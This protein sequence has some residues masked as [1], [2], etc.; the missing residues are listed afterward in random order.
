VL[1][2]DPTNATSAAYNPLL[3]VRKGEWEVRDV[4]N[5]TLG[6]GFGDRFDRISNVNP[7]FAKAA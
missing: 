4:H 7:A 2:F 3:E 5:G 1:L 6:A